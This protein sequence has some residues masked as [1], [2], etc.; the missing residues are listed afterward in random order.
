MEEASKWQELPTLVVAQKQ[1][2][3]YPNSISVPNVVD[4]RLPEYQVINRNNDVVEICFSPADEVAPNSRLCGDKGYNRI[5]EALRIISERHP[6]KVRI[7]IVHGVPLDKCLATKQQCHICID[8]IK[9][10]GYHLSSLEG[11]A[12]G[13]VTIANLDSIMENFLA[14]YVGCQVDELPWYKANEENIVE[15]MEELIANKELINE[16]GLKSR[17]W[18]ERYWNHEF[19]LRKTHRAY[20]HIFFN[21]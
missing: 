13:C 16:L 11:L 2:R 18:M 6:N 4:I 15:R 19:V 14:D 17:L 1:A 10:G 5:L 20:E 12:L 9:S 7:K 3:F 8:D 21:E